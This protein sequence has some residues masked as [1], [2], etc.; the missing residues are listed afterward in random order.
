VEGDETRGGD[1]KGMAGGLL[2]AR[3]HC[4]AGRWVLD[5]QRV[6]ERV[7]TDGANSC[8]VTCWCVFP[9]RGG[10]GWSGGDGDVDCRQGCGAGITAGME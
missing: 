5:R 10:G 8:C 7:A 4:E 1:G 2:G 9:A 3:L 6:N